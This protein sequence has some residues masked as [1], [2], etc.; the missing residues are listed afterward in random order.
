M[1]LFLIRFANALIVLCDDTSLKVRIRA[2]WALGVL[3]DVL[4]GS[5][6]SLSEMEFLSQWKKNKASDLNKAKDLLSTDCRMSLLRVAVGG[7]ND[8]EKVRSHAFRSLG[9]L[10]H[11]IDEDSFKNSVSLFQKAVGSL[12][13]NLDTG[14]FKVENDN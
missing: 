14:A 2:F 5:S 11:L 10:I 8:Q 1:K 3:G 9:R 12:I 4:I 7:C 6:D 13:K